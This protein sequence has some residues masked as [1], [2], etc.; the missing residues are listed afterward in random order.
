MRLERRGVS[1]SVVA[2][3]IVILVVLV[4]AGVVYATRP[5]SPASSS[6]TSSSSTSSPV[7]SSTTSPSSS[8]S[9]ASSSTGL[10]TSSSTGFSSSSSLTSSNLPTTLTIDETSPP[11]ELNPAGGQTNN[12]FEIAQNVDLPLI[13]FNLTSSGTSENYS[14][15]VGALAKSWTVSPDGHTWTFSLRSGVYYS[16]GDPVN[17]YVVWYDV[18]RSLMIDVN[19]VA[20]IIIG[21]YLNMTGVTVAEA[22]SFNSSQNTPSASLLAVMENPHNSVTVL[23]STAIQFHL[24]GWYLQF[25]T[26]IGTE[27][28]IFSDPYVVATHGG[29]VANQSNTYMAVNGTLVGDGPY[30]MSSTSRTSTRSSRPTR[31]TGLRTSRSTTSSSRPRSAR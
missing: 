6:T 14:Q 24:Q 8:S 21:P 15:P 22:N 11:V 1:R 4:V 12:D 26:T 9:P 17:A 2:I 10:S 16:N 25:L 31:T 5:T 19:G 23:N 29:I 27:P 20:S 3:A 30:I 13:A 7:S 28:W 18:Y